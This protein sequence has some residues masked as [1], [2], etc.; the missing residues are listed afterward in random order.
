MGGVVKGS[1]RCNAGFLRKHLR[2]GLTPSVIAC[3]DATFPK[4]TAFV[5]AGRFKAPPKGVPLGKLAASETSRLKG[6]SPYA[7]INLPSV[8]E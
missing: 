8:K 4:G 1:G 2:G 7:S 5:P 6:Y 3:G